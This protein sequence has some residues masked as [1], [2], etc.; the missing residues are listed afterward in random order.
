MRPKEL[1]VKKSA[2]IA[3]IFV[4]LIVTSLHTVKAGDVVIRHGISYFFSEP[5]KYPADFKHFDYVNPN[6]PKGGDVRLAAIGTYDSLNPFLLK[7]VA[8]EG[9]GMIYDTLLMSSADEASAAYGLLAKTVEVPEKGGWVIFNLRTNARWHDGKP[10]TADDVVFSFN[11]LKEKGHPYYQAYYRDVEKVEALGK[12][13]VKFTFSDPKNRELP[14]IVGQLPIL[15]KHYYKT[16]DFTKAGLD[17]PLS[18]GPYRVASFDAGRSITYAR[19]K[20]Y[21][22]KNLPVNVGRYN[23]DTIRYDY[24]RDMT[25]AVE[26]LKAG[27]YDFRQENI[28]KVWANAYNIPQVKDGR[29]VKEE[30]PDGNPTGMQCFVFN[31]RK[32]K[33]QNRL[34]REAMSYAYDFEWAN[35][36]LFYGAY[37]RNRSFFGN[38]V[39]EEKGVPSTAELKLLDPFRKE[40][41]QEVFTKEYDPP[42][43]DGSGLDRKNLIKARDL[44]K[45]AGYFLR[46]MKLIDPKTNQP[47]TIEFLLV[48]PSFERVVAP[49]IKNLKKL[50]IDAHIRTV[51]SS[52][53]IKRMENFDFDMAIN[54][55][56]ESAA[57]GNEQ[58]DYWH[59]SK[60]DV[61]GSKNIIGIKNPAVDAMVEKIITANTKPDL[62]AA[63][64]ALDRI[65]SWN[66]YVI[67]QWHSRTYRLIYWNKFK[68]PK[69]TPPY[70]NGFIDT[71]W[72]KTAQIGHSGHEIQPSD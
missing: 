68:R 38:S 22:A 54:W 71:W 43:T 52:Q 1:K 5:L 7:G 17:I 33:F 29:M 40:L 63:T 44:L 49:Y 20:D 24:Y 53:Y 4:L 70:S 15:P 19:V 37:T 25:V 21:W 9:L 2:C 36:Q 69:I 31:I 61:P 57:P 67:P 18:S 46:N 45:Q 32:E 65:L 72:V 10:V 41:P 3:A 6:A 28:S 66:F 62:V 35:E 14:L 60:A 50:G 59:S 26:A 27:E 39:Y 34:F 11:T 30:L 47:V 55:F 56:T 12:Y 48:S 8:A 23:Y 51:D 13:K 64:R 58:I 16:H 42:K